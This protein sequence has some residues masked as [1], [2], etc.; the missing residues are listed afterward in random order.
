MIQLRDRTVENETIRLGKDD[1]YYLGPN[2]FLKNCEL[3]L[4]TNARALTVKNVV[5]EACHIKAVQMLS[6]FQWYYALIKESRFTGKFRGCDFGHW[7]D[8]DPSTG[9]IDGCDFTNSVLDG[10]RFLDCDAA[11][12]RFPRWPCF[13]ILDPVGNLEKMGAKPWPARTGAILKPFSIYPARTAAVTKY[14]PEVIKMLGGSLEELR[15]VLEQFDNV[16]L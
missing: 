6:E 9:G 10:C 16:I 13:T 7:P 5:I 3:E 8:D 4:R 11:T 15:A 12:L 14:A 1:A 2:L